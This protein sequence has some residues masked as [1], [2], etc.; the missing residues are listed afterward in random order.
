MQSFSNTGDR[1]SGESVLNDVLIYNIVT[2]TYDLIHNY[3]SIILA[4]I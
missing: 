1:V 3:S 4:T 2:T